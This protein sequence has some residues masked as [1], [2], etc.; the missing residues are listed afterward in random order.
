MMKDNFARFMALDAL[1]KSDKVEQLDI[2]IPMRVTFGEPVILVPETTLEFH[3]DGEND[4]Y[5]TDANPVESFTT[6]NLVYDMVYKVIF[7]GV[8]YDD[9]LCYKLG[10]RYLKTEINKESTMS[11]TAIGSVS[12]FDDV[13][14]FLGTSELPFCIM[15]GLIDTI[16]N[17]IRFFVFNSTA[18]TH[19]LKVIGI[20]FT[21]KIVDERFYT[22]SDKNPLVRKG[23]GK[24]YSCIAG[25]GCSANGAYSM[26]MNAYCEANGNYSVASGAVT[27]ANGNYSVAG[28]CFSQANGD[29]S[30]AFGNRLSSG[31]VDTQANGRMGVAIGYGCIADGNNSRALG[32]GVNTKG[33]LSTGIG[34]RITANGRLHFAIGK[35]NL[36]EEG[37]LYAFSVGNGTSEEARSNAFTLDWE[38]NGCYQG[39]V[40]SKSGVLKLG[41]TE[42]T[43]EQLKALLALLTPT[44]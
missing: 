43:E 31:L 7:D 35:Y 4:W 17:E 38:G 15:D 14:D 3:K 2:S 5:V 8:E 26:A 24:H 29:Y 30:V 44:A 1:D 6:A 16:S 32:Q 33:T 34:D 37:D 9:L 25:L 21:K 40:E 19:T 11:Y 27:S 13:N 42:V 23:K 20:P 10:R 12:N 22:N 41:D 18:S 28:G 39:K 36:V